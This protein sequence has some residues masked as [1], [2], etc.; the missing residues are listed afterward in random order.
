MSFLS[1]IFPAHLKF[2]DTKPIYMKGERMNPTNYRPILLL[3]SFLKVFEKPLYIRL[4]EHFYSSKLLVGN[5][6]GFQKRHSKYD[7]IFKLT[8][9]ILNAFNSKTMAGSI[10]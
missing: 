6:Y 2:S 5:Q 8:T 10:H 4:S 1:G 9:V 3:T 7:A